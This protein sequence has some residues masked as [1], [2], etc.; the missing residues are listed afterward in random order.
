MNRHVFA[1]RN[2]FVTNSLV[3]KQKKMLQFPRLGRI[4]SR[5][6][7]LKWVDD[8]SVHGSEVNKSFSLYILFADDRTLNE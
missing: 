3:Q 2:Y 8:P 5:N 4:P 1:M 7:V 6:A